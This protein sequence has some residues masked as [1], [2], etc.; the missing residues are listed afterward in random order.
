MAIVPQV[1]AQEAPPSDAVTESTTPLA[2]PAEANGEL[3]VCGVKLC[4]QNGTPVQLRG[5]STHG[6]QWF[7][8]CVTSASLDALAYDWGADILRISLYVQED[9]YESNPR[10]FTDMVHRYI[11][12]ATSRGMYALVDW[13]QLNPGDPNYTGVR[14][15]VLP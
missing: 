4:N 7:S 6:I 11:E 14:E 10:K 8:Q 2:R 13:H 3:R 9:G 1:Q 5:I 15:D 12:E